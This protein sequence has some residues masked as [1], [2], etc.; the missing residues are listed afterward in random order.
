MHGETI[1]FDII[2]VKLLRVC[3]VHPTSPTRATYLAHTIFLWRDNPNNNDWI[4]EILWLFAVQRLHP[5]VTFSALGPN[6]PLITLFSNVFSR[7]YSLELRDNIH[8]NTSQNIDWRETTDFSRWWVKL[9]DRKKERKKEL[10]AL[11]DFQ[12]ALA[13]PHF[14]VNLDGNLLLMPSC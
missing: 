2:F 7:C 10:T 3:T 6:I 13:I 8:A 1:K 11:L 5:G 14:F 9:Q 12:V 4:S